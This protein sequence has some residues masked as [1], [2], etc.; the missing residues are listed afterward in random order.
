MK[1]TKIGMI[2]LF[3]LAV[4]ICSAQNH[5]V[6]QWDRLQNDITYFQIEYKSG[7]KLETQITK[8]LLREGDVLEGKIVNVN[9]FIFQPV[10]KINKKNLNTKKT[11]DFL[12]STLEGLGLLDFGSGFFGA[13]SKII[14]LSGNQSAI[15]L[16]TRGESLSHEQNQKVINWEKSIS[17][18]IKNIEYEL[19]NI[20]QGYNEFTKLNEII[21]SEVLSKED[22]QL[23]AM[24]QIEKFEKLNLDYSLTHLIESTDH[25]KE[26]LNSAKNEGLINSINENFIKNSNEILTIYGTLNKK[27]IANSLSQDRIRELKDLIS[28][29]DFNYSDKILIGRSNS[30]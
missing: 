10:V 29:A 4:G 5:Y 2:C 14:D 25:I 23:N 22:F 28:N 6:V 17:A 18:D 27:K 26:I 13:L 9:E 1:T 21:E 12:S 20:Q 19:N 24:L 8:P 7:V 11:G 16:N 30:V 3:F 15:L